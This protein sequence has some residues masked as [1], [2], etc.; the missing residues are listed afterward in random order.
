MSYAVD[1]M[2]TLTRTADTAE[3]WPD[4]GIVAAFAAAGLALGAATLGR[5][6]P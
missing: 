4:V 1:A 2:Q 6:T 3:V 5:R